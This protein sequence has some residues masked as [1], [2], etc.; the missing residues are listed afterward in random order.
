MAIPEGSPWLSENIPKQHSMPAATAAVPATPQAAGQ[1]SEH[2]E[3]KRKQHNLWQQQGEDT[4]TTPGW[5][6]GPQGKPR[7]PLSP[8]ET[9]KTSHKQHRQKKQH[10]AHRPRRDGMQAHRGNPDTHTSPQKP[11]EFQPKTTEL[12]EV[13]R[14]TPTTPGWHEGLKSPRKPSELQ[15]KTTELETQQGAH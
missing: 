15:P 4:P 2:D 5:H 11:L 9:M 7:H 14:G 13:A 6:E 3:L 8:T 1:L 10:R 12:E